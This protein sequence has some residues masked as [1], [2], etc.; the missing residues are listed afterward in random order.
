MIQAG[1][2][3]QALVTLHARDRD[4]HAERDNGDEGKAV[5]ARTG[6]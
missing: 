2:R 4:D 6:G 3:E 5:L 1:E